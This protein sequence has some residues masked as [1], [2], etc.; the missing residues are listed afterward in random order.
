VEQRRSFGIMVATARG[1]C[2]AVGGHP[3]RHTSPTTRTRHHTTAPKLA[4][5]MFLMIMG[6]LLMSDAQLASHDLVED[7]PAWGFCVFMWCS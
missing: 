6:A 5:G 3:H 4:P 1:A 2:R 7:R